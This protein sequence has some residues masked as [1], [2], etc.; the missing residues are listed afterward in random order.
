MGEASQLPPTYLPATHTWLTE[1]IF[2]SKACCKVSTSPCMHL[3]FM[4]ASGSICME[5][6]LQVGTLPLQEPRC[7]IQD[8]SLNRPSVLLQF[9]PLQPQLETL[10]LV[11]CSW[12]AEA[13]VMTE[14]GAVCPSAAPLRPEVIVER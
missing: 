4:L 13:A 7:A 8:R 11:A 2:H 9:S 12:E 5:I 1:L 10:Q 6:H 3:Q 14:S